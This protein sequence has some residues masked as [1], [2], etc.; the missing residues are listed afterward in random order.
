MAILLSTEKCP[1]LFASNGCCTDSLPRTHFTSSRNNISATL[2]VVHLLHTGVI[3][4]IVAFVWWVGCFWH[5]T[6]DERCV[7]S[8]QGEYGS[9]PSVSTV[10]CDGLWWCTLCYYFMLVHN[11]AWYWALCWIGIKTRTKTVLW[12]SS[13][14]QTP[15]LNDLLLHDSLHTHNFL[16]F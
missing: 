5:P 10:S 16:N 14:I 3:M 6:W 12:H 4:L 1:Q 8:S 11:A 2:N 15:K 9:S 7:G 13:F